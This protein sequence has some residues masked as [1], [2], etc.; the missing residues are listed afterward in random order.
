MQKSY[1]QLGQDLI[2]LKFFRLYPARHKVF[3]DIGAFDGIGFSNSR[4]FFEHGWS[5][6]CVEPVLKNF[7]KLQKLYEGTNVVT[8]R[9]AATDHEG[10]LELNVATIP[11]AEDWG[12]DVSSLTDDA[13]ERWPDYIWEKEV[14]P[15]TTV[16]KIL[17]ANEVDRV[18][19]VSIDVEGQ[20]LAVLR[21]FD[22]AKYQPHLIVVEYS[23]KPGRQELVKHL[24]NQGYFVWSD[25]G[26]DIFAVRGSKLAHIP[27]ILN[28]WWHRFLK[29]RLV[30]FVKKVFSRKIK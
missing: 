23:D 9:A 5:G 4:L 8:V 13:K 3:L 16:N 1:A 27:V 26:Q 29:G 15:A 14:V 17:D 30:Q 22:L 19:F 20:E 25:N 6:V 24:N 10:Q 7:T 2:A 12:S 21:G 18:D 11:W 28:G